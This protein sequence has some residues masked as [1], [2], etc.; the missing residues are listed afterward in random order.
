[1]RKFSVTTIT[2]LILAP[3]AVL[4]AT[5]AGAQYTGGNGDVQQ[6]VARVSFLSGDVSYNRGDQPD[7]W[8]D[9]AMNVPM[10]IGDRLYLRGDGRAELQLQ[11]GNFVRLG[12]QSD[13]SVLNLTD[14]VEQYSLQAGTASFRISRLGNQE[15]FEV[16]TPNVAVTFEQAGDYRL[17]V[18][19]DGNTRVGVRRGQALVAAGGGQ[20]PLSAGSE[21]DITGIDSPQYDVVALPGLDPWD[22]WVDQRGARRRGP[23][24]RYVN[25]GVVGTEDL[26]EYGQWSD[27]PQ[28][29]NVWSPARVDVGW[30]PYRAGRW[31]WQDPWGWTWIADEPWGWAPY[32]YGRWINSSSR[33][34]W[35]PV[36]PGGAFASY[37]PALVA[38]VGGGPGWSASFSVGGGGYMGWFPLAPRDPFVP[39]WGSRAGVNVN[40]TNV[41]YINRNYVTVVNHDTFV[42]GGAVAGNFVRDASVIRQVAAAPVLRGAL[43]VMPAA[44]ALRVSRNTAVGARPPVQ[45]SSRAVV[46]RLAPPPAPPSFQSKVAA[47]REQRGAPVTAAAAARLSIQGNQGARAIQPVRPAAAPSGAVT[48]RERNANAAGPRPQAVTAPRGKVLATADRPIVSSPA[49]AASPAAQAPSRIAPNAVAAPEASG[50]AN[51]RATQQP[52]APRGEN[53]PPSDHEKPMNNPPPRRSFEAAPPPPVRQDRA[54]PPEHRSQQPLAPRGGSA[55]SSDHQKEGSNP[56]PRRSFEAAPSKAQDNPRQAPPPTRQDNNRSAPPER[57][58]AQPLAPRGQ[59][60]APTPERQREV[61]NPPP[62]RS[63]EAPPPTRQG[64][65]RQAPPQRRATPQGGSE[66]RPPPNVNR[67]SPPPPRENASSGNKSQEGKTAAPRKKK[68]EPATS[69][70]A[71]PPPHA[72]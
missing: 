13:L 50:R 66:N 44:G 3:L 48:F 26:D 54:A 51:S 39:W 18:D 67:S 28:Y 70:E 69:S 72:Q 1:M 12:A 21:M 55:T 23:S 46:T 36:A 29:G 42:S 35:V 2:T 65:D 71:P 11:G 68:N 9:A 20:V 22:R 64:N 25:A 61:N 27:I 53:P 30:Q 63:V 16:D 62:K 45:V 8:E 10:T 58:E 52:L 33:W 15:S 47:I 4:T 43:P 38:F 32:H 24:S 34:F 60:V 17:D 56:P 41:T 49:A 31:G 59:S 5:T 6:S 14:D 19:Q 7:V 40:V 37:S 57:R